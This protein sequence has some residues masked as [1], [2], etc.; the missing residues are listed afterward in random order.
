MSRRVFGTCAVMVIAFTASLY[1]GDGIPMGD[2]VFYP[3][4]E[5]IYSH[6]DNLYMEDRNEPGGTVS[7]YYWAIHPT[8]GFEFP[9]K[10]S[11]IR[12]NVGY[13]YK[14]YGT[15]D[16]SDHNTWMVDY[17]S[18]F[19]FSNNSTLYVRDHFLRGVQEIQKVDPGYESTFG[20]A[21][22]NYNTLQAG[23]DF[24]LNATNTLGVFGDWT[25][26][27]FSNKTNQAQP[28][29]GYDQLSG[30]LNYRYHL[31]ATNSLV[32]RYTYLRSNPDDSASNIWLDTSPYKRYRSNEVM[33]GWEGSASK[34]FSGFA[35]LGYRKMSFTQNNYADFS[36]LT[37][38]AGMKVTF[39][40][41]TKMDINVYR[42][43]YQS[44]Y[45]VNNY[46][47]TEGIQAQVHQQVTRYFFW[48]AGIMYQQNSYPNLTV[49]DINGDTYVEDP[50]G[51]LTQGQKR[52]DDITRLFGELGFHI[53]HQFSMRL[54][55][56]HEDRDSDINY[57]DTYGV[58]RHPF[59]YKEDRLSFQALL[60]W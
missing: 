60:G 26:A 31:S 6:T 59:S 9:F 3:S 27:S 42:T 12:L 28:F 32:A 47:V 25:K 39:T 56:Q 46:Y 44:A 23:Y 43:P 14:D 20:A 53:T 49:G 8:L 57:W 40:D 29:Y 30:G 37:V 13:Q 48:T 16:L 54:N 11:F 58:H 5:A 45:N 17:D 1:A 36:G 41:L 7:D 55:Y 15:Y 34:Y 19:K 18:N 51:Y 22:F 2:A 4:V 24:N 10:Q 35:R 52:R 33:F 50:I 38:D 21:P